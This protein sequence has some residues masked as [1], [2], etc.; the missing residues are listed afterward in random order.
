MECVGL[1][2]YYPA[3]EWIIS[4]VVN[5]AHRRQ[6]I[7]GQLVVR[8]IDDLPADHT[9]IKMVNVEHTHNAMINFLDGLGFKL[10]ATPFEMEFDI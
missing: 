9:L 5:N 8:C 3:L 7:A 10:Y 1:L 4:L 2:A 6:G